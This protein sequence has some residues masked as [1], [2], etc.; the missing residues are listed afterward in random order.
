MA[1]PA[2]IPLSNGILFFNPKFMPDDI[3]MMLLGPGVTEEA[4]ANKV[5]AIR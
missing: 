2:H 1:K 5:T 3:T 4:I